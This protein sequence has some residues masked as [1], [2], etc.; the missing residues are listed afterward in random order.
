M[1]D[2]IT[3]LEFWNSNEDLCIHCDTKKKAKKMLHE[4]NKMKKTWVDGGKYTCSHWNLHKKDTCY[5]NK[6]QVGNL[7]FYEEYN[8][9]I[10]EFENVILE[11]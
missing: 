3:L 11:N 9:K 1:E 6:G 10:Y 8:Y 2:K 7:H 5:N 4:F